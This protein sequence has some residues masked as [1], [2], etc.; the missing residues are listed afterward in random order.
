[1]LK[2]AVKINLKNLVQLKT[3]IDSETK[4]ANQLISSLES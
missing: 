4:R 1:M 2:E 3:K